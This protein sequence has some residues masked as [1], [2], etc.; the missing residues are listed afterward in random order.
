MLRNTEHGLTR[1]LARVGKDLGK[2]GPFH[3]EGD[4][5][6]M[7]EI[8]CIRSDPSWVLEASLECEPRSTAM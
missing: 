4:R 8:K 7:E 5:K 6:T 2:P 3:N 1:P